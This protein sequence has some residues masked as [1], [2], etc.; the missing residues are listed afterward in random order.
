MGRPGAAPPSPSNTNPMDRSTTSE[1]DFFNLISMYVI[2]D[3][4]YIVVKLIL[5]GQKIREKFRELII[6]S[7]L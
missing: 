2:Y 5:N 1:G 4:V 7:L 6:T 3:Y